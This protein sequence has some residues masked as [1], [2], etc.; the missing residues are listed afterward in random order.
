MASYHLDKTSGFFRFRFRY[1]GVNYC[2]S[3]KIRD[4]RAASAKCGVIEE[5]LRYLQDG[6]ITP[7][8]GVDLGD[9]IVSGGK[10]VPV[11]ARAAIATVGDLF[12]I[13]EKEFQKESKVEGTLAVEKI[14]REHL[15]RHF[16]SGTL[17][18]VIDTRRAQEYVNARSAE[19]YRGRSPKPDTIGKEF[20]TF[21]AIWNWA[22]RQGYISRPF[23]F[24]TVD[25]EFARTEAKAP[26]RTRTEIEAI[27][28][29]GRH[30]DRAVDGLWESLYLTLAEVTEILE[31]VKRRA[32]EPWIYPMLCFAACA[33]P[34]RSEICR[35][36]VEDFD[37]GSQVVHIRERKRVPGADSFR[38]V[39][40]HPVLEMAMK[41]WFA[42]R[43][44]AGPC[45]FGDGES[46]LTGDMAHRHFRTTFN[47]TK[48][49]VLPG[50]HTF[51]H[52]F[53]SN[54]V[55]QG[56]DQRMIDSFMGHQTE[57]QRRRYRHL[58]PK[59]RKH[60]ISLLD[61]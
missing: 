5:T 40:L 13:Y 57:E 30:K 35:S 42:V 19:E 10:L 9:W 11:A 22:M 37:F 2:R 53:C 28:K 38:Y 18:D 25:L 7:P 26:F 20:S 60:A 16:K 59:A 27:L 4:D 45:A 24:R 61:F 48:W 33:G 51:R 15:R 50:F 8:K 1:A 47:G 41:A 32:S 34:R 52:S 58:F 43:Q 23:P 56:I 31:L 3:P 44:S 36:E 14:H 12:Q 46:P 54:L 55:I 49:S 29:R 39:D 17:L 6:V 21:R